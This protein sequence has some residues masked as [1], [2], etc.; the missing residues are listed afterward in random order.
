[1]EEED[2]ESPTTEGDTDVDEVDNVEA[3]WGTDNDLVKDTEEATADDDDDEVDEKDD[4]EE[5]AALDLC[6]TLSAVISML[7]C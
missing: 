4:D 3:N 5:E 6:G 7:C 2:D 1:V